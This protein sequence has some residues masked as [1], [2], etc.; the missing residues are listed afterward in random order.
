MIAGLAQKL[1]VAAQGTAAASVCTNGEENA[2][3]GLWATQNNWQFVVLR[4][5]TLEG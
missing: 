5:T 3:G 2:H 4:K 1:T